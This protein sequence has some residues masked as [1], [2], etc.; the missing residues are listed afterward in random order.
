SLRDD[1]GSILP[2]VAVP[3]LGVEKQV[4]EAVGVEAIASGEREGGVDV[5]GASGEVAVRALDLDA[6]RHQRRGVLVAK[7]RLVLD[8]IEDLVA[9]EQICEPPLPR[10]HA[11]LD[12]V[13]RP[14]VCDDL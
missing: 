3:L 10:A 9:L 4:V 11:Q 7:T 5:C 6:T 2:C 8:G 13:E 14:A 1:D 12:A